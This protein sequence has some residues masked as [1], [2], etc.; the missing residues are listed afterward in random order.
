MLKRAYES[1][2]VMV[3]HCSIRMLSNM[4]MEIHIWLHSY[5]YYPLMPKPNIAGETIYY[6]GKYFASNVTHLLKTSYN[7]LIQFSN[8]VCGNMLRYKLYGIL[9]KID[10]VGFTLMYNKIVDEMKSFDETGKEIA[11]H[12]IAGIS[13]I[14]EN[15]MQ[16][17]DIL[18]ITVQ[19]YPCSEGTDT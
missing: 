18:N 8:P 9:F 1:A 7:K 6:A 2:F 19:M 12:F 17:F 13:N 10:I 16:K 11:L 5:R 4:I 3:F 14:F 15:E